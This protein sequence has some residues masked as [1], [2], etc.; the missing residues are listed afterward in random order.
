MLRKP[1]WALLYCAAKNIDKASL[2]FATFLKQCEVP[3]KIFVRRV[4]RGITL[5]EDLL[6]KYI[7]LFSQTFKMELYAKKVSA[8][9]IQLF[10]QKAP[11]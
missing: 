8:E 2:S 1:H 6:A 9:N 7:L 3:W 4:F 11:S 10:L 5:V